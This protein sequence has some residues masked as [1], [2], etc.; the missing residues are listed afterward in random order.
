MSCFQ[1]CDCIHTVDIQIHFII[2]IIL[3]NFINQSVL[4]DNTTDSIASCF[5]TI[6][7]FITLK[8]CTAELVLLPAH[9]IKLKLQCY[10]IEK[11]FPAFSN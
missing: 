2:L 9:A 7:I 8:H 5:P 3:I 10:F 11:N 4:D 1:Q 6:N